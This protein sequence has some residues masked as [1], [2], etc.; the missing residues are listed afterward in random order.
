MI[1][2]SQVK[3]DVVGLTADGQQIVLS[4]VTHALGWSE[5]EKELSAKITMKLADG[6][7]N[8]KHVS[9][10]ILPFTPIIIYA[11]V[12]ESSVEVIRGSVTK[13][14]LHETNGEFFLNIE[15]TD[16]VQA[17]RKNQDDF[18]FTDGYTT[19]AIL[20]EI[21]GKWG[22]PH[23]LQLQ[24][25]THGKKVYR[26]KYL[27]DMINDVLKDLKEKGG[28]VY[29][30]RAKNGVVQIIP[31]GTNETMYH[32]DV[33]DTL[34]RTE[35]SFDVSTIVTR[36]Q[37]VG[38][39]KSEGH[40][41]IESTVDGKIELGTRQI[42]YER[43]DK[44]SLEEAETAAKKILE[45]QGNVKRKSSIEAPDIPVIRKG[46][47]IRVHS[48]TGE[49]YFFIKSIRHNAASQKM[50]LELDEDK[51][52]SSAPYDTNASDESGSSAPP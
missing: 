34:I 40:L 1:D 2:L 31:R 28:G 46:D 51:E 5:G 6:V 17:L 25:V 29:F 4:D 52:K 18:F 3:Y 47:R 20:E 22:V 11:T 32:F 45:E 36:V 12:G 27:I 15:A 14:G 7:Y 50:T 37:V 43:G 23:E 48:T 19:T 35:E 24:D 16:E 8:G 13:W 30:V 41:K 38:K 42:I 39:Q 44:E 49:G 10:L 9:E 33:E 21:L 26:K